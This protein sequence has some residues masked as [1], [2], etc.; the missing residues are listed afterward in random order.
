MTARFATSARAVD[1]LGR[2]QIATVPTAISEL[3]KNAYDAYARRVRAD[4]YPERRALLLRDDGVGM[5]QEDF[6]QRWL[7]LGT[8]SK[9]ADSSRTRPPKPAGVRERPTMGEKGIGRLAVAAVGPQVLVVTRPDRGRPTRPTVVALVQWSMF[10]IPGLLL[11]EVDVPL[12]SIDGA[13]PGQEDVDALARQVLDNLERLGDRVPDHLRRRVTEEVTALAVPEPDMAA[14]AG[15]VLAG[16]GHGT[17]FLVAPVHEELDAA[18]TPTTN[19]QRTDR[20]TDFERLLIGFTNTMLPGAASFPMKASFFV[21]RPTRAP[22]DLI[23]PNVFWEPED[24][25]LVDHD[26]EGDFDETGRFTG[27]VSVY[28]QAPTE[29]VVVWPATAGG[30]PTR[31]GPFR[32][33]IGYLQGDPKE[34]RL[35]QADYAATQAKLARIG[36][37]YIYRD[38]IRVLPYGSADVDYLGIEERRSRNAGRAYFS[39]RRMFGAVEISSLGNPRLRDKASREGLLDNAA[40]R[41]FKAVLENFLMQTAADFFRAGGGHAGDF[42]AEKARLRKQEQERRQA[43]ARTAERRSRFTSQIQVRLDELESG[44]AEQQLEA[45][46]TRLRQHVHSDPKL[47]VARLGELERAARAQV[48]SVADRLQLAEPEGLGLSEAQ[49]R[50]LLDYRA[51]EQSF[52]VRALPAAT[53]RIVTMIEQAAG[54]ASHQALVDSRLTSFDQLTSQAL[55]AVR[56]TGDQTRDA[57]DAVAAH[58]QQE[59]LSR[60]ESAEQTVQ[61]VR[62]ELAQEAGGAEQQLALSQ[63]QQHTRDHEAALESLRGRLRQVLDDRS[64]QEARL[65]QERLLGLEQQVDTDIDLLLLGQAVQVIDHELEQT[66]GAARQALAQLRPAVRADPRLRAGVEAASNAFEHLDGYLRLFTPLQRRLRRQRTDIPG[67]RIVTFLESLLDER[68]RRHDV[69]LRSSRAFRE[70]M[71]HG[72]ASTFLPV[73]VNLVDNAVHWASSAHPDGGGVV[74][75]DTDGPGD[76]LV[77]D[78][79]PGVRDR[80]REVIFASGFTRRA[81]GRGLGLTISQNALRREGWALTVDPPDPTRPGAT[82]RL[83]REQET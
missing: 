19:E 9:A 76:L 49:N 38:G 46:V 23:A 31:C 72:F 37:L 62:V 74:Q 12:I 25:A 48:Q 83:H 40:F 66:V 18:M 75:L 63:V 43:A 28:G 70:S 17:H 61:H 13:W 10:E 3:F 77:R 60:I 44:R 1:M 52:R 67:T 36:G 54:Q 45:V 71:T 79:G 47:P 21:H 14:L 58:V 55:H 15:P 20:S 64:A 59:V 57:L 16:D 78:N 2:Q 7:V 8:D 30:R 65:L 82:F 68:M 34:S 39:Y 53:D 27:S 24:F 29:H 51:R 42:M 4:Y 50:D 73:F 22:E 33:R 32:V 11:E 6:L 35:D 5:S 69:K 26:I 41:D 80:D 81:G 56:K